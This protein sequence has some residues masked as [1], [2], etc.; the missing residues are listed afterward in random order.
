VR[1]SRISS[2]GRSRPGGRRAPPTWGGRVY[3]AEQEL[4]LGLGRHALLTGQLTYLVARDTSDNTAANG[5]QIPFHPRYTAYARPEAV[6]LALPG[7]TELGAYADA[8]VR[9]PSYGDPANQLAFGTRVL[10]G[11]GL[12][13]AWP[14]AHVRVTA[15]AANLT[16]T[17]NEDIVDWTLPGRSFFVALAYAPIGGDDAAI[18]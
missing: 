1:W 7:G 9:G 16:N 12:S 17:Q 8:A 4:R 18:N 6:R 3:G 15:S 11:A 10:V 5:R 2:S 14:R 13:V